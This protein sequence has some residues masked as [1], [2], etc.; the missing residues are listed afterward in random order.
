MNATIETMDSWDLARRQTK[1]IARLDEL[2]TVD[3]MGHRSE[4][5]AEYAS[6]VAAINA[7]LDDISRRYQTDESVQDPD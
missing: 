7:E 3:C 1:L 6:E 5:S 2:T 4:P